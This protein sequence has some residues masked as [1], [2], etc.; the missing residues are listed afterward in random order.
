MHKHPQS[1]SSLACDDATGTAVCSV[2]DLILMTSDSGDPFLLKPECLVSH[3]SNSYAVRVRFLNK[4]RHQLTAPAGTANASPG[5]LACRIQKVTVGQIAIPAIK[6]TA[7]KNRAAAASLGRN[8]KTT[9]ATSGI[10]LEAKMSNHRGTK[11][12]LTLDGLP[13]SQ[14]TIRCSTKS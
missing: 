10:P 7:A 4:T 11:K 2:D 8:V 1:V 6:R 3:D 5:K 14:N 12:Q 13:A 9:P